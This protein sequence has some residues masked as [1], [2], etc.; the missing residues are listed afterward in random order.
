[1]KIRSEAELIAAQELVGTLMNTEDAESGKFYLAQQDMLD[2]VTG[3]KLSR[4]VFERKFEEYGP[5]LLAKAKGR[6][7]MKDVLGH[8]ETSL[9]FFESTSSPGANTVKPES[10]D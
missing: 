4:G 5:A 3:G 8:I 9:V 1:M 6:K 2:W 10:V 7:V